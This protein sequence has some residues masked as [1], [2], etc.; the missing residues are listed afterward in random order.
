[1]RPTKAKYYHVDTND[2]AVSILSL[3]FPPHTA[4]N[5]LWAYSDIGKNWLIPVVE[6]RV[7]LGSQGMSQDHLVDGRDSESEHTSEDH[8]RANS[9]INQATDRVCGQPS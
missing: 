7:S 4:Q 8:Y 2:N 6:E 5:W 1:M 9:Q 3:V